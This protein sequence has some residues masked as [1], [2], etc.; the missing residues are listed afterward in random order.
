MNKTTKRL[1]ALTMALLLLLPILAIPAMAVIR[2][3]NFHAMRP[4]ERS[5][6]YRWSSMTTMQGVVYPNSIHHS[7]WEHSGGTPAWA[8]YNL[9]GNYTTLRGTIGRIDGSHASASTITFT[10]DHGSL[11]T[12]TVGANDAPRQITV[13]VTGVNILR[14]DITRRIAFADSWIYPVAGL[15]VTG[16]SI[17]GAGTRTLEPRQTLQLTATVTPANA[18]VRDVTWASSNTSVATV[19]ANGLVT[20]VA[21]GTATITATTVDGGFR[22]SVTVIVGAVSTGTNIFQTIWNAIMS[23]FNLIFGIFR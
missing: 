10:G 20:A 1:L 9:H 22:A 17:P 4:F 13:D 11:G 2:P 21:N 5:S 3:F 18:V 23:F 8:T 7:T 15:N 19:N 6:S 14:I 16:V 12:F